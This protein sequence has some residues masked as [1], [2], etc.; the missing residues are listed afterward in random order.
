MTEI[1]DA[2]VKGPRWVIDCTLGGGGHTAG[3]LGKAGSEVRVLSLDLDPTAI[4]RAE[5]RF[6]SEITSGRLVLRQGTFARVAQIWKDLG[7]VDDSVAGVVADLG[8]SSDQIEDSGRGL[9]FRLDGPLDMRLDP[10]SGETAAQ[11]LAELGEKELADLFFQLGEERY[12][13]RIARAVVDRRVS[14]AGALATTHALA[15]LVYRAVPPAARHG[16]IHPATRVFQALRIYVND[17]LGALDRFFESMPGL[18][19]LGGRVA[20]LTFHSLEDRRAKTAL[21]RNRDQWRAL[22]KKAVEPDEA[23]VAEN[24][25]ARSAKLRMAQRV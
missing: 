24:P 18:V 5:L 9:S 1:L 25:R 13:R 20:V 17:E 6:V 4:A 23:E 14:D 15:E 7:R 11:V 10:T 19:A 16:R 8:F 22:T 21:F 2:P 3:I 12:S